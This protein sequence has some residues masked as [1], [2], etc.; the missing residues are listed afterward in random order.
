[1]LARTLL[2]LG[3][4]CETCRANGGEGCETY[5][6]SVI[7]AGTLL[8]WPDVWKL[9]RVGAAVPEDDE[10]SLLANMTQ[11]QMDAAQR[12]QRRAAAGIHPDDFEAFDSGEMSGYYPDGSFKPG[13]NASHFRDGDEET[14]LWLP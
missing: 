4:A 6:N 2:D 10:C 1:M 11:H 7:P 12:A 9:V 8:D 5:P 13:P 3:C 14:G